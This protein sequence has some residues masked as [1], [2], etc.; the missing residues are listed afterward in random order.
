MEVWPGSPRSLGATFDGSG[1]LFALYSEIAEKVEL[2][3]FDDQGNEKRVV[4]PE[5]TGHVW[6]GYLPNV[7]VGQRYA[8]RVHGPYDPHQGYFC[9]PTQLLLDPYATAIEGRQC[10]VTSPHFDWGNDAAPQI[11]LSD[12]VIYELHVKGFTKLN[13]LVPPELRGTYAALAHPDVI[14]Y[15]KDLGVTA[16]ELL[17]VH[18]FHHE[19]FLRRKGLRQ[20]WGY[21]SIGYFAPHDEYAFRRKG[22]Q[23]AEFKTMVQA[24]HA[25]RIEVILDVV[26][27][28]TGEGGPDE[29]PISFRGIDNRAYYRTAPTDPHRYVDFTG[30]GNTLDIRNPWVLQLV[31]DSLRYW[32]VEMHVDGFRFDLT[33]A[34]IREPETP[35]PRAAFLQAVQQDPVLN[36]SKLI[37][38]PWDIGPD[39]YQ[40]GAFPVQWSEWNGRY[41]DCVRDFWR[42]TPGT[43]GDLAC[44]ISGSS[45]I[46]GRRRPYASI[47]F[48]SSHDGFTL[49]DLVSYERKH[50]EDNLESNRD[51]HSDSR[52]SNYG[53]EGESEDAQIQE[54]RR[55]QRQ[56]FMA[57]LLLSQGVPMVLAGR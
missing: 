52:S 2:C 44:R 22:H 19:R 12:T 32:V 28:H 37:A 16:V 41:R 56:N 13:P 40:L 17:P 55:R 49:R 6:H 30:T 18:Q 33:P 24:L 7:G 36:Q 51:G 14:R 11:P 21:A 34:L 5:R 57:T 45:D 50:N 31:M 35:N 43:L 4:L 10:W 47:N 46:F 29:R 48:I 39:G 15:L 9:D 23:V 53:E 25:A 27:N 8:Y 3:L 38:E 1:T 42:G 54:I 20:F 26:Y